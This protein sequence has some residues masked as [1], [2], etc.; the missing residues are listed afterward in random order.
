LTWWNKEGVLLGILDN[1]LGHHL[2]LEAP[3]RALDRLALINS[4]Y[5]HSFSAFPFLA[6]LQVRYLTIKRT[7]GTKGWNLFL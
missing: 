3:Q 1:L 6:P 2:T 7:K 4:N 5:C